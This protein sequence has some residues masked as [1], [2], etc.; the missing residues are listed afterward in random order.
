[1]AKDKINK[2]FLESCFNHL[3][4]TNLEKSSAMPVKVIQFKQSCHIVAY[5][6]DFF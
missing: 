1:M 3:L 5:K 6:V 2:I 4:E